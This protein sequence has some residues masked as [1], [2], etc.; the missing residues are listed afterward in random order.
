M[1]SKG[2]AVFLA[3]LSCA[4]LAGS[5]EISRASTS[6][7]FTDNGDGTVTDHELRLMWAQS[8]NQGDIDWQDAERYCEMGPPNLLGKYDN[9]RMPTLD[10][11]RSL[12]VEDQEYAGYES[13]C[14]QLVR[15][16]PAIRLSCGWIWCA[17]K[18]A[19]SAR[20]FTFSRG[21]HY[22]DRMSARRNYRALPVR[23][24]QDNE[25]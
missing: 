23:S 8:D 3:M 12:Y 11:L 4:F 19:I 2:A 7:R 5:M 24:L 22:T 17:E 20:V 13:D 1:M 15:I 10:E 14:G 18:K 25:Q 16:V 9:W 21:Y 6:E